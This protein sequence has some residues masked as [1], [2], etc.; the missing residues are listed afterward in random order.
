MTDPDAIKG[1][2]EALTGSIN[3]I[4]L[5]TGLLPSGKKREEAERLLAEAEREQKKAEALLAQ[6]LGFQI[7]QDCWPPEIMLFSKEDG[8]LHCRRCGQTPRSR[9]YTQKRIR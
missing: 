7:C 5:V 2:A 4:R 3:A 6:A 9:V 8:F 1:W